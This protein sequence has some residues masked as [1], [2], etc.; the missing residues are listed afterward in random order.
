MLDDLVEFIT[1]DLDEA[2]IFRFLAHSFLLV[3]PDEAG[4]KVSVVG[5]IGIDLKPFLEKCHA[6]FGLRVSVGHVLL[7]VEFHMEEPLAERV[8]GNLQPSLLVEDVGAVKHVFVCELD[9]VENFEDFE[10]LVE[11]VASHFSALE[12]LENL[13]S[14]FVEFGCLVLGPLADEHALL[15]VRGRCRVYKLDLCVEHALAPVVDDDHP[16]DAF[17]INRALLAVRLNI[18]AQK[19]GELP[20]LSRLLP[21]NVP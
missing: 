14:D 11:M 2:F 9:L 4:L 12:D 19:I 17:A 3:W 1:S 13:G 15:P 21:H 18:D 20:S 5:M 16:G 8:K 6:D 10:L 7:F